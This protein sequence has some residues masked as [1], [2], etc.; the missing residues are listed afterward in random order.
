MYTDYG[1]SSDG[2]AAD[3]YSES[4]ENDC[5]SSDE[6]D[7]NLS[8]DDE[9]LVRRFGQD[10]RR[11]VNELT[12][13]EKRAEPLKNQYQNNT[14]SQNIS[15]YISQFSAN[16]R[17]KI[18]WD[19]S[20]WDD[21]L[22]YISINGSRRAKKG[23]V[24]DQHSSDSDTTVTAR[25]NNIQKMWNYFRPSATVDKAPPPRYEEIFPAK[26]G[27]HP[28]DGKQKFDDAV[29]GPSDVNYEQE[30]LMAWT[31]KRKQLRNDRMLFFFWLPVLLLTVSYFMNNQL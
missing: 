11:P 24:Q 15:T 27:S 18:H 2:W 19:F 31:T 7:H 1:S 25:N 21:V 4:S 13:Y 28:T 12:A 23:H 26:T 16:A 20:N 22:N 6:E 17:N 10:G 9:L 5:E 29:E 14:T 3:D 30:Y 8:L